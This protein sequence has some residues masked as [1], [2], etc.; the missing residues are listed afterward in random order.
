MEL[1]P[2][3]LARLAGALYLVNILGGFFAI[4]VVPSMTSD[5][6][7]S[8]ELLYRAGLAVHVV[9]TA[10]NVP[11][12]IIFFDLFKVVNRRV[13][14]LVVLFTLVGT[15]IEAAGIVNEF[16]ALSTQATYVDLSVDNYDVSTVFFGFYA[17]AMGY[18]VFRSTFMP[19]AIG[20]LMAIDGLAYVVNAFAFMLSPDFAMHLVPYIQ[21]P[22]L[23]G[24]G[25]LC[26]WLLI[27][28]VNARRW[29]ERNA[30]RPAM[31]AA[32]AS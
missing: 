9:V 28:G 22:A 23:F 14:L 10:T 31:A 32:S 29:N 25:S 13:A 26:L 5:A 20:V 2:R 4:G 6:V 15:S 24:E 1:S 17:I 7:H 21:L 18:V 30:M 11:L 8:H 16:A 12:A 27:A 19:R 3:Q